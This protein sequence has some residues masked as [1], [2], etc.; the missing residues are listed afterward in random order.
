[1]GGLINV[2]IKWMQIEYFGQPGNPEIN[3][4][5]ANNT[6]LNSAQEINTNLI[7]KP[8]L[9]NSMMYISEMKL[10]TVCKVS[11]YSMLYISF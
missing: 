11:I 6:Q 1:M 5:W 4:K 8:K 7:R 9:N 10:N 2:F 3:L